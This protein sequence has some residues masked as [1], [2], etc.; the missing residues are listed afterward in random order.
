MVERLKKIHLGGTVVCRLSQLDLL[1]YRAE[2][3]THL[4]ATSTGPHG[5]P[6]PFSLVQHS[7]RIFDRL[8]LPP[9]RL[10]DGTFHLPVRLC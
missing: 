10:R 7:L 4:W 2:L 6:S 1:G 5:L 3:C 9:K 8:C